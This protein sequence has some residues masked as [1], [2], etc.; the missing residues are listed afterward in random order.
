MQISGRW[1]G[2]VGADGS[3]ELDLN[4][5]Y[6]VRIR[7]NAAS[8]AAYERAELT[9]RVPPSLGRPLTRRDIESSLWRGG[10]LKTTVTCNDGEFVASSIEAAPPN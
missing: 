1:L 5:P 10:T 8:L 2:I 6:D 9:I 4:P 7:V 3:T